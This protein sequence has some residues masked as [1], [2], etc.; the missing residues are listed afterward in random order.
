MIVQGSSAKTAQLNHEL[1]WRESS[2][3]HEGEAIQMLIVPS[4]RRLCVGFFFGG[5]KSVKI[6][7]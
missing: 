3:R 6:Q 7:I 1:S 4:K 2:M 5:F